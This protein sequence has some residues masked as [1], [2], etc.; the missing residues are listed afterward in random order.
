MTNLSVPSV[1]FAAEEEM[2]A[3][4]MAVE[5]EAPPTPWYDTGVVWYGKLGGG[6]EFGGDKDG[7]YADN[8]SRWGIKGS[9]EIA[10][11]LSAVY[12]FEASLNSSSATQ[13]TGDRLSYMGLSG[14]FGNITMGRVWSA[15]YNNS[16]SLRY[17][18][19]YYGS[20]DTPGR[21]GSAVSYAFSSDAASMQVDAV[22]DSG[23]DTGS[24]IDEVQFGATI[25]FGDIGKLGLGYRKVENSMKANT[26]TGTLSGNP[27]ESVLTI[28]DAGVKDYSKFVVV[29]KTSKEVIDGTVAS[30]ATTIDG[31]AVE[32]M[33]IYTKTGTISS[34]AM[35]VMKSG[36]NLYANGC[37]E[38]GKLA[39]GADACTKKAWAYVQTTN[40]RTTDGNTVKIVPAYTVYAAAENR[41][42]VETTNPAPAPGPRMVTIL[43][44]ENHGLADVSMA[45]Y[46][47][48]LDSNANS[49]LHGETVPVYT[50]D[51]NTDPEATNDE[52]MV[53]K[54]ED[55][56]YYKIDD[57]SLDPLPDMV[58]ATESLTAVP[59]KA[60]APSPHKVVHTVT[61]NT[62][63]TTYGETSTHVTGQF[64]LGVATLALGYSETD[65]NNPM[66]KM[67][68]E[69]TFLG[70][71]GS[72]GD[73]GIGWTADARNVEGHDG[74]ESSPWNVS[75]SKSLGGGA[76]AW[77]DHGNGDDGT[78]G[79][80]HVGM[81]VSF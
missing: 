33:Q 53:V 43:V 81:S 50:F 23:K 59:N 29:N 41:A 69:T 58:S 49:D 24:T 9:A 3:E 62:M 36:D 56:K 32:L 75:L 30:I 42:N 76:S 26:M 6:I 55:D 1:I 60:A 52:Y 12:N 66:N 61:M 10:D 7:R 21:I 14:G 28:S 77:I 22:M 11:G 18:G 34:G 25:N 4:E 67:K 37:I 54:A 57:G 40:T 2:P 39:T 15:A 27:E 46:V 65:S 5:E 72:I 79:A 16:G 63:D 78:G 51:P 68:K 71:N 13:N 8:G 19:P 73:T 48:V 38:D 44:D 45:E 64:N 80:T 70:L 17:I 31:N 47:V 20:G 74:A 35:G